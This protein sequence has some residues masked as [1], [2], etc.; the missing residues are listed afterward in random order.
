MN[1]NACGAAR[2][3][4]GFM[5]LVAATPSAASVAS[6]R[7]SLAGTVVDP[8]G[9]P[10]ADAHV[11]LT[12]HDFD[13]ATLVES[14][15]ML[16]E[17]TTDAQ[18]RFRLADLDPVYRPRPK[19]IVRVEAEGFAPLG[20]IDEALR[21]FP[22]VEVDL[23]RLQ[24]D[25][26]CYVTG[27]VL[28]ADGKPCSGAQVECKVW[29]NRV[30]GD[31][32]LPQTVRC[33]AD[34]RFRSPPLPMGQV[35]LSVH[36]AGHQVASQHFAIGPP[37]DHPL[38]EP[39]RLAP[40][41]PIRGT[42]VDEKGEPLAGVSI[43][44]THTR[45][46]VTDDP[47][48][49]EVRGCGRG[50]SLPLVFARDGYQPVAVR[51]QLGDD[52]LHVRDSSGNV[53]TVPEIEIQL[54][55][56][57]Y[58]EGH[59]VDAETLAAVKIDRITVCTFRRL[60]DRTIQVGTCLTSK[61]EQPR[62]GYFRVPYDV[63]REYHLA[64]AAAG[65]HDAEVFTPPIER[66]QTVDGLRVELRKE[67]PDTGPQIQTQR[68]TGRV[69]RDGQPVAAGWVSLWQLPRPLGLPHA[70]HGRV[71]E[72]S[73]VVV[74]CKLFEDGTYSIDAPFQRKDWYLVVEEN[75]RAPTQLGPFDLAANERKQLDVECT[76][77]GGVRGRVS[78]VPDA[79]RGLLWA[80]AFTKTGLRTQT[81]VAS[82][83]TFAFKDLA[84]GR[85]GI[86]VGHAA[87]DD[88]DAPQISSR[89]DV[90]QKRP[91]RWKRA[92]TVDV[93]PGR[94]VEGVALEFTER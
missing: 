62:P 75:G 3:I 4:L 56:R 2:L 7:G 36:A 51:V 26:P 46:V 35:W 74:A 68:V 11:A 45:R 55:P 61:F 52:G 72:A 57:A 21:L 63:P 67:S 47:G 37:G 53:E 73:P 40:D 10:V 83:G 25:P 84:P 14:E 70:L 12:A 49:F 17:T 20:H 59:A 66:L 76:A 77:G 43:R 33:G 15:R 90:E 58:F 81:R 93:E 86:K 89:A 39:I 87:F 38:A 9:R 29:L 16:A 78:G 65:Y 54:E 50:E 28:D 32:A 24:L 31:A 92:V 34:G 60:D 80:I 44:S 94:T 1:A 6:T 64:V 23:G 71:A 88:V 48:Q 19:H 13:G 41:V 30:V 82:D 42:V 5:L 22:G 85:Y 91:D 79:W 69:T 18:G 8:D 27:R